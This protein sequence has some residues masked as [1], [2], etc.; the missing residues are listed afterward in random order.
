MGEI[1]IA[2]E[3]YEKSIECSGTRILAAFTAISK[4]LR[5]EM[6]FNVRIESR[7]RDSPKSSKE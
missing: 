3:K 7:Q 1:I 2:A 5:Y 4:W 6:E